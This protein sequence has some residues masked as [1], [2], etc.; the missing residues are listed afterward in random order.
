[1]Q[2]LITG[3]F[4]ALILSL[5]LSFVFIPQLKKLKLGQ[6]VRDDGPASHLKKA[7]TPT[8]GGLIF[9][10]AITIALLLSGEITD[11]IGIL[12]FV[13]I[14]T[15]MLG[16]IDDYRKVVQ[17]RSLGL[18]GRYK[19]IGQLLIVAI[20]SLY[21]IEVGHTTNVDIPFTVWELEIGLFYYI[22]LIFMLLGTSNAV[23]ITDG[24]DGLAA[25]VVMISMAGFTLIALAN[26]QNDIAFFGMT[27]IGGC[28]GF[29]IFN[30]HP[31]KIFMGDVGSL[32]LGGTLASMAVLTKAEL[33]LI[34]IGL[35]LVIET[36]SVIVQVAVFQTT[37]QRVLKMSPVHHHLELSGWS[38]W[39]VVTVFWG[40]TLL[41]TAVSVLYII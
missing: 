35:P 12:L 33:W 5:I 34:I 27:V 17:K 10:G 9:L 39:K 31:A 38:E 24:V 21:L 32:A 40:A 4:S 2:G 1:M 28:L 11:K 37:G 22:L 18:Q 14:S 13:T 16:L 29:I 7:G 23:N 41:T 30:V 8:M 36:L 3:M 26:D 6:Y 20:I 19:V 15:G 25:G